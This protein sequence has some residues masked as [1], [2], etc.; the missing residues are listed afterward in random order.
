MRLRQVIVGL[1]PLAA[2]LARI[3]APNKRLACLDQMPVLGV[4]VSRDFPR[5]YPVIRCA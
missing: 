4:D 3:S 5:N 1:V 2:G